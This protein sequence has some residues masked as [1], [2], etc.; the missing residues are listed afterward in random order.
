MRVGSG[1]GCTECKRRLD[2]LCVAAPVVLMSAFPDVAARAG[3]MGAAA[4]IAK[5]FEIAE[6]EAEIERACASP[7]HAGPGAH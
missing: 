2:A 7:A 3:A 6:L 1:A 5:P 4:W